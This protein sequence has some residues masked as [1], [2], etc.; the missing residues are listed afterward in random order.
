MKANR[1]CI[2]T[3][4]VL[5]DIRRF[6]FLAVLLGLFSSCVTMRDLDEADNNVGSRTSLAI[7]SKSMQSPSVSY[8]LELL[9][10]GFQKPIYITHAGDSTGRLFVV[11]QSGIIRIVTGGHVLDKPFLDLSDKI[12]RRSSEQGLLGLAFD[13]DYS[14]NGQFF[15]HYSDNNGDTVVMRLFVS[16]DANRAN[17]QSGSKVLE[18]SQ[19]YRNHNG[20]QI[21]FG[22]DGHLYV[23]LGDGGLAG[24]PHKNGQNLATWLGSILRVSIESP[25][26]YS[27]PSDNPFVENKDALSEIWAYGLRNPWRFSFDRITGDLYIADVG[28]NDWEEIN[29]Q[30]ADSLGG[31]NYG[32]S[33]MEGNHCYRLGCESGIFSAP[34]AEYRH[35]NGTCSV[36]GGYVYRGEAL[37][38]MRGSYVY[39]DFCS[40]TIWTISRT[41]S[42]D[43]DEAL[44]IESELQ[45]SSFGED[46][47]GEVYVVDYAGG[48]YKIVE[49][50]S[51]KE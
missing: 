46:E 4:Y 9:A 35:S 14:N 38:H 41:M 18:Q 6:V 8:S 44:I 21:A 15:V 10:D 26:G 5:I 23:G 1:F 30:P 42:G 45:I 32:W 12:T 16:S 7:P 37:L 3:L 34:I 48:I 27:V 33:N 28:Q 11:E 19:P 2:D 13:P 36:T 22:P 25:V 20:G 24:D 29:F 39:G 17:N 47:F 51:F 31:E 40:G 43:W 50:I 49:D